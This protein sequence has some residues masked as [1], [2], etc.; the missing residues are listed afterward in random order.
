[1]MT[2]SKQAVDSYLQLMNLEMNVG[3]REAGS[4]FDSAAKMLKTV[5]RSKGQ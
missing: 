2:P 3:D 5:L 4:I 1:M